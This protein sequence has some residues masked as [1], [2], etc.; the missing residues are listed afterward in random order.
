MDFVT[1][2]SMRMRR[3]GTLKFFAD[4]IQGLENGVG[5]GKLNVDV[6]IFLNHGGLLS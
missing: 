6:V 1:A 4:Q 2:A 5:Y 3:N